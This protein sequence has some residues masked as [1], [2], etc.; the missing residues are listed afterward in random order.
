MR[1]E[2][3]KRGKDHGERKKKG[4]KEHDERKK[5]EGKEGRGM[6]KERRRTARRRQSPPLLS[7]NPF[8]GLSGKSRRWCWW[9]W[10]SSKCFA[11]RDL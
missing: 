6:R 10:I 1:T 3:R 7:W 2:R 4:R 5:K 8:G 11:L 9:C